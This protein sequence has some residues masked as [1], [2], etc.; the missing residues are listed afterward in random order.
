MQ[1]NDHHRLRGLNCLNCQWAQSDRLR[2]WEVAETEIIIYLEISHVGHSDSDG[3]CM[4]IKNIGIEL[5]LIKA[6]ILQCCSRLGVADL[7]QC[8]T[9]VSTCFPNISHMCSIRYP[10]SCS[11]VS[12]TFPIQ[13]CLHFGTFTVC[14]Y[15]PVL[16]QQQMCVVSGV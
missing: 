12:S 14:D 9:I 4:W 16:S 13:L 5:F 8:V 7:L 11:L 3:L 1:C 2:Q 10:R 6:I 15:R